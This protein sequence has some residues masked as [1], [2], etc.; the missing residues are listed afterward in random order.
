MANVNAEDEKRDLA[1]R[2]KHGYRLSGSTCVSN[3]RANLYNRIHGTNFH[4]DNALK[5]YE[6]TEKCQ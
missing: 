5:R 2:M 3:V 4:D 6:R 1:E